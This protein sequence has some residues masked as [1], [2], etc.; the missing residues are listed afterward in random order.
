MKHGT[1]HRFVG[2]IL[3]PGISLILLGM[4]FALLE[5]SFS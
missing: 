2:F 4:F 5:V 3:A 1:Q